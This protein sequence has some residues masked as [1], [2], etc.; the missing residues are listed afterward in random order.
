M[1]KFHDLW[2][3][4]TSKTEDEWLFGGNAS[5]IALVSSE[6]LGKLEGL[7]IGYDGCKGGIGL[8]RWHKA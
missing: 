2:L 1:V 5:V 8:S 7:L 3:D 4:L 6:S